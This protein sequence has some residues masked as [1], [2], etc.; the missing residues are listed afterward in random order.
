LI[1]P[2][3]GLSHP[4]ALNISRALGAD[5]MRVYSSVGGDVREEIRQA[6]EDFRQ[7][8]SLCADYGVRIGYE[9]H[10]YESSQDI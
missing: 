10:E 8:I 1:V 4:R 7:V 6:A 2:L 3:E 5:R 9:N